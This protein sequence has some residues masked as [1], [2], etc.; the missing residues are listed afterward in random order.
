V[1][2]LLIG[3]GID[4]SQVITE[5]R[6][7]AARFFGLRQ[8]PQEAER[9][10]R[11]RLSSKRWSLASLKED[12]ATPTE[13]PPGRRMLAQ[14]APLPLRERRRTRSPKCRVASLLLAELLVHGAPKSLQEAVDLTRRVVVHEA[15]AQEP[16][17][18]R[19]TERALHLRA[20]AK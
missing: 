10:P 16:A 8:K 2:Q 9:Q 18:R 19:Q 13:Q 20:R 14:L 3:G 6:F 11:G 17:V 12:Q 4:A 15:D 7:F 1:A 5:V